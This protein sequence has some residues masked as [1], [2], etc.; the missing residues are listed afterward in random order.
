MSIEADG[1]GNGYIK[2]MVTAA[3]QAGKANAA[4]IKMLAQN[5]RLAKSTLSVIH[6]ATDRN[7]TIEVAGETDALLRQLHE[8]RGQYQ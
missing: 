8:W 6:G 2:A 3:P 4:L 5:W 7:K 1:D